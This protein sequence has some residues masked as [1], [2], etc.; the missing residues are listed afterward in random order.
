MKKC[1]Y[2]YFYFSNYGD[3]TFALFSLPEAYLR[4]YKT[5]V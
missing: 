3:F 1:K 4:P 5:C 2:I